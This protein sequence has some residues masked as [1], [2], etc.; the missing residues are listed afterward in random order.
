[1]KPIVKDKKMKLGRPIKNEKDRLKYRVQSQLK[2][3]ELI[4]LKKQA[5]KNKSSL[6]AYIRDLILKDTNEL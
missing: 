2:W 6:S 3:N 1:M 4:R 5:K